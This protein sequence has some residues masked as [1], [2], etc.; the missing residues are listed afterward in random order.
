MSPLGPLSRNA[1]PADEG[2]TGAAAM[3]QSL[4]ALR[5]RQDE[6]SRPGAPARGLG[7]ALLA[8]AVVVVS[9]AVAIP[10]RD[11]LF[12]D[13][14]PAMPA[15]SSPA[16]VALAPIPAVPPV[17]EIRLADAS[18]ADLPAVQGAALPPPALDLALPELPTVDVA[19]F[20]SALAQFGSL[21]ADPPAGEAVAEELPTASPPLEPVVTDARPAGPDL[22]ETASA[23]APGE[24]RPEARRTRTAALG[25]TPP[26]PAV[27]PAVPSAP[28]IDAPAPT[29]QASAIEADWLIARAQGQIAQGDISGARLLLERAL[30][31]GSRKAAFHLAETYDPRQLA[32]WRA[33]GIRGDPARAR[34]LY[35]RALEGGIVDAQE[36]LI[37]LR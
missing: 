11:L 25:Q 31:G 35:A 1:P 2:D 19:E 21:K 14:A 22:A 37:G 5:A 9:G 8:V 24:A 12:G 28:P 17:A 7:G 20:E 4:E 15:A 13:A 16:S 10:L 18:G 32:A 27:Q 30:E 29:P 33:F 36:R 34:K 6:P 3:A 23:V 26:I